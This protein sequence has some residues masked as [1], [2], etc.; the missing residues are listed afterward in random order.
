MFSGFGLFS[1]VFSCMTK[2]LSKFEK[3]GEEKQVDVF[4]TFKFLLVLQ[5]R[6]PSGESFA[7]R[8]KNFPGDDILCP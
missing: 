7:T 3:I 4:G 6:H 5:V 2:N 8:P 1:K